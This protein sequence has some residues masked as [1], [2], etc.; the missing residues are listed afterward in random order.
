MLLLQETFPIPC[1]YCLSEE[2]LYSSQLWGRYWS[3]QGFPGEDADDREV[4]MG[5]HGE[6]FPPSLYPTSLPRD[7]EQNG[8]FPSHGGGNA[9][10]DVTEAKHRFFPDPRA[11]CTVTANTSPGIRLGKLASLRP[12]EAVGGS[13]L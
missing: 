10:P 6:V 2:E 7:R 13:A 9:R 8:G 5:L 3:G 4:Q 12:E 1:C 11:S